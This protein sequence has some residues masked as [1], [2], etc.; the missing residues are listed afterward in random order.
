MLPRL[1]LIAAVL[2]GVY[3]LSRWWRRSGG[4]IGN[5]WLITVV[6]VIFLLLLLTFRGGA[7]I[8]IPLLAVLAPLLPRWMKAFRPLSAAAADP[9]QSSRRSFV[10]TRFLSME[11]NHATGAMSGVVLDGQFAQ[12]SLSD[13]ALPELL[14]LWRDCQIDSQ[15]IAVLETYLDRCADPKWRDHLHDTMGFDVN[16]EP[17]ERAEAYRILGLQPSAGPAEIQVAY[18]RLIQ[19]LHPDHGG[20]AYLATQ[21]N[22][23]RKVLLS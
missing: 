16:S 1:L 6:S 14:L 7:E 13:L 11:L 8:A 23:A 5:S 10:T 18:R 15:S 19:R 9:G 21:L 4:K 3:F 22:R 12:R 17:M 2:I 20:S